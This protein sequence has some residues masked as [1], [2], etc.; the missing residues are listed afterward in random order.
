[1]IYPV[2]RAHMH[3]IYITTEGYVVPCCWLG[4]EPMMSAYREFH[5]GYIEELSIKNRELD[6]ILDDPRYLRLEQS[7]ES[8]APFKYCSELCGKPLD[9][10]EEHCQGSN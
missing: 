9:R 3:Q 8:G 1:M 6:E 2:C 7:W 4:N 10:P 5:A